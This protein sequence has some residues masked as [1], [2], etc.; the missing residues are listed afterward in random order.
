ML[1]LAKA[2]E[3]TEREVRTARIAALHLKCCLCLGSLVAHRDGY[4]CI[5]CGRINSSPIVGTEEQR[6]WEGTLFNE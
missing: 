4:K 5:A 2:L 1:K 3:R 6:L